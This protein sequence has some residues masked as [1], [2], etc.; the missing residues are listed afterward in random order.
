VQ[1]AAR[2]A[3]SEPP[4]SWEFYAAVA[5]DVLPAYK[6]EMA[7]SGR[8]A[9]QMDAKSKSCQ[10][11]DDD[12]IEKDELRCGSLD[13]SSGG[14]GRWHHLRC[15]RV[16]YTIWRGLPPPV[17]GRGS[18]EAFEAAILASEQLTLAGFSTLPAALKS[19]FV[20]H[21]MDEKHWAKVMKK[22]VEKF[23]KAEKDKKEKAAAAAAGPSEAGAAVAG[24]AA[25]AIVPAAAGRFVVPKPGQNGVL[26]TAFAAKTFVLTGTF[27][28]L[29]GGK[30][31][32]MGKERCKA[33][34]ASFGGRVT[35]S[36]SGK[37]DFL[38]VG[39]EPGASK[40]S[41]AAAKGVPTVD[42][43]GLK[44]VLETPGAAL[45]DAPAAVIGD[46]SDG[47][48]VWKGA[49]G[50][51]IG[52]LIEA[53]GAGAPRIKAPRKAKAAKAVKG[54]EEGVV[55]AR[56]KRKRGAAKDDDEDWA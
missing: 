27:P 25:A 37:T 10:H 2:G 36:V 18:R 33:L 23:E 30:G 15:W 56:P 9:C 40:V 19:K 4:A 31:L 55:A 51:G 17:K 50:N 49:K 1:A 7:V 45:E 52:R 32:D 41:Q 47:Y 6:V 48:K 3:S 24:E 14:Y 39:K 43:M 29:G 12:A 8:S 22:T 13:D 20:T 16:P 5:E 46:F 28:E 21:L 54:D 38:V 26:A 53:P 44:R 42:L 11:G 35:G 34:I